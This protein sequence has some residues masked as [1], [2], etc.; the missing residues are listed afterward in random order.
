MGGRRPYEGVQRV[1]PDD[2]ASFLHRRLLSAVQRGCLTVL[3][4]KLEKKLSDFGNEEV[5][6]CLYLS[7]KYDENPSDR[8]A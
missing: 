6:V 2:I 3:F 7:K 5:P 1:F 4:T 8:G